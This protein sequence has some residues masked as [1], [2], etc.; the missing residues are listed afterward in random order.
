MIVVE[1]PFQCRFPVTASPEE[2]FALVSD[3]YRS[4]SHFPGVDSLVSVDDDGRWRWTLAERGFG[5]IK[6]RARYQA[7]YESDAE[8][9]QVVWRPAVDAGDME[10]YGSWQV[11]AAENGGAVLHFESRTVASIPGPRMMAGM[12]ESFARDELRRLKS[13]YV[14]AIRKTL[15]G[16]GSEE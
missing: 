15:D 1:V 8:R 2:A 3:V 16:L 9:M 5:P 14:E 10:S 6:M 11:E 12:I 7:V 13:A 4:G